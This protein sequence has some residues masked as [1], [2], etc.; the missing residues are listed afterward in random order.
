MWSEA[1]DRMMADLVRDTDVDWRQLARHLR[2]RAAARQRLPERAA[3]RQRWRSRS[4]AT[5]GR[6]ARRRLLAARRRPSGWTRARPASARAIEAAVGGAARARRA[7]RDRG[8]SSASP[9][10]R[11]GSL[12]KTQP[13]GYAATDRV[14]LVSSFLASLLAGAHAPIDPGDGSGMN[15]MDLARTDGGA[16]RARR[17]PR[18]PRR[19]LPPLAAVLDD[20]R[21][22]LAVLAATVRLSCRARRRLVRRQPVQPGRQRPRS[23]RPPRGIAR[24]ERH[25][26][27]LHARAAP[28]RR[29]HRPR[30]RRRRPATTWASSSSRTAR[31]RASACATATVST[32]PA[33]RPRS[34][35]TPPGNRGAMMLPW[36]DPEITPHVARRRRQR[37][38]S[39]TRPTP[40]PTS[41]RSSK[42]R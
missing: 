35:A 6:P 36:F 25:D 22:A 38:T 23:R 37:V 21:R 17:R 16:G 32:G 9:A 13:D 24:H 28:R 11:S 39:S 12:P 30:V 31:S 15:L 18:R 33:S 5:A 10:R 40:R 7:H 14:H 26:L 3:P 27:R 29:R 1:L 41:A 19:E 2:I 20:R 42:G 8:R 34:R 4:V